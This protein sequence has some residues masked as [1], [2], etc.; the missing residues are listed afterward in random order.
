MS[1]DGTFLLP[2]G[3][4]TMLLA[5]VEGSTRRWEQDEPGMAR[6]TAAHRAVI[7]EEVA[8]HSGVRPLEQG[9]GD[10]FV[11][12]FARPSDAV[13]CALAVARLAPLPVRMAVHTGEA[14]R[15]DEGNYV[16]P[17]LNRAGRLRDAAHGGQIVLSHATAELV[18]DRL[19][20]EASLH[21]LGR[22]RLKDLERPERI[23]QLVHPDLRRDFPALRT[24]DTY[25]H[26]LP[27]QRT[28]LF[29][30]QQELA[31]VEERLRSSRLVT[32]TGAGGCGKTRL[33]LELAARLLD[34]RSDGVYFADLSPQPAAASVDDLRA[35]VGHALGLTDE[36]ANDPLAFLRGGR[37]LLVLDNCEHVVRS[38][39]A[40]VD[41]LL[42]GTVELAILA[43][44]R[45]VLGVEGEAA[46]VLPSLPVPPP[47][48]P[49]GIRGLRGYAATELFLDCARRGEGSFE[50]TEDDIGAIADICRRL[51]GIPLAIELAAARV[52]VLSPREIAE[53]LDRRFELLTGGP[54]TALPRQQTLR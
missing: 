9:E 36:A 41:H 20:K 18:A 42:G 34:D 2:T 14:H 22:H 12:A 16:G 1:S 39:A 53:G 46:F 27:Q 21:D 3:T 51:D 8:A 38:A 47:G 45:E 35:A 28:T 5:D 50:P 24:L 19:P 54:R 4:V 23:F 31:A 40:L 37:I 11:A 13:A 7:D 33:S 48:P 17:S 32:V 49:G 10:S 25:R 44:S 6:T 15:T 30:R 43:T 52:R 26:N 29:G